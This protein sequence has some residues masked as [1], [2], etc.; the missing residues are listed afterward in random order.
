MINKYYGPVGFSMEKE[1]DDGIY[2]RIIIE[3]NYTGEL[4]KWISKWQTGDGINDN[5]N[6]S[7]QISII[8]DPFAYENFHRIVYV[9]FLKSKWKVN[10]VEIQ[11]PR[12]ILT[13]G[14][15]YNE[16]TREDV[17]R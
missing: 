5:L 7:N 1:V 6:M 9:E 10:S 2:K 14:G 4:V 12:L 13:I 3:H 11:Y 16:N 15:I 8:A 17:C